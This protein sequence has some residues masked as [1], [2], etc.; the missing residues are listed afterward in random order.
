MLRFLV[1]IAACLLVAD[2]Q[3]HATGCA[4]PPTYSG[5]DCWVNGVEVCTYAGGEN[6]VICDINVAATV[7]NS[8]AYAVSDF[9]TG[10]PGDPLIEA[11][12]TIFWIDGGG[13]NHVDNFCCMLG[14]DL[15]DEGDV[16]TVEIYGGPGNDTLGFQFTYGGTTYNQ[17]EEEYSPSDAAYGGGGND[18]I[19]G[20][21]VTNQEEWLFGDDGNDTISGFLGFDYMYGGWGRDYMSGGAEDDWM[22]GGEGADVLCGDGAGGIPGRDDYL[23][24]GD[25]LTET[26][27]A[28]VLWSA[29]AYDSAACGSTSTKWD[30]NA[31]SAGGGP[32]T[33]C[34]KIGA[35]TNRYSPPAGYTRPPECP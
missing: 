25:I 11:W 31:S 33:T 4:A 22:D 21:D 17:L 7:G 6:P 23:T 3:A 2:P 27:T 12:G 34:V 18:T 30:W 32:A 13:V 20:A 24:D 1:C 8:S 19:K 26:P 16:E 5:S 28:D 35:S 14:D 10:D 29:Q 15:D 9:A